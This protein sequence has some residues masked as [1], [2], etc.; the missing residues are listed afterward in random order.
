MLGPRDRRN[1]E[2]VHPD[3][4]RVIERAAKEMVLYL[5]RLQ[6]PNG[7]FPH[8]PGVPY[9]WGRGNGW[10]AAGLALLVPVLEPRLFRALQFRSDPGRRFDAGAFERTPLF[11]DGFE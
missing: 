4:R 3:L 5:D 2:N 10:M 9:F 6:Q 1:L 7:L 8:A 11:A